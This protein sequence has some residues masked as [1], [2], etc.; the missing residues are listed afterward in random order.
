MFNRQIVQYMIAIIK[1][2]SGK[3]EMKTLSIS[4]ATCFF[5]SSIP[6][7]NLKKARREA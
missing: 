2:I 5:F 7:E 4:L 1:Y 3:I 6:S